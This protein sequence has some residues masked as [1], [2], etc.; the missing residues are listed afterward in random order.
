[1][2]QVITG[3]NA[4]NTFSSNVTTGSSGS[5]LWAH[6]DASDYNRANNIELG[7]TSN[8]GFPYDDANFDG[9]VYFTKEGNDTLNITNNTDTQYVANMGDGDDKV[10]FSSNNDI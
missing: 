4:N 6:S 10:S 2:I 3:T 9:R 8:G 7:Q 1:M 5:Y